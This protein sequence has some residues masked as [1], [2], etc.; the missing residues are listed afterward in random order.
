LD[1]RRT[2]VSTSVTDAGVRDLAHAVLAADGGAVTTI[3]DSP[4]FVSQRVLATIV[5]IAA[6][7]AQMRIASPDDINKAVRLGLAYPRG[8]LEFG[9]SIGA[10]R[11][12]A[13]LKAMHEFYGDPR[14]RPSPWLA[15]RA[16]L[17]VSLMTPEA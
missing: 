14:Y 15:R 12:L 16:R 10:G 8:P 3:H 17:G 7:I 2:L 13:I 9:D 1:G 4:G 6:E 11:I 5:N